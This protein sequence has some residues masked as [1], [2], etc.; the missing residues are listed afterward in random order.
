MGSTNNEV[1]LPSVRA[2]RVIPAVL[3]RRERM[4]GRAAEYVLILADRVSPE[5]EVDKPVGG[6]SRLTGFVAGVVIGATTL[7]VW[8]RAQFDEIVR[9]QESAIRAA[10]RANSAA[11]RADATAVHG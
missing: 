4:D 5:G 7:A 3:V 8:A 10:E 1:G 2:R 6:P 9:V 11:A